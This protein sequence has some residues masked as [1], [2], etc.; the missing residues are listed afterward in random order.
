M[1]RECS[2]RAVDFAMPQVPRSAIEYDRSTSRQTAALVRRSV[3]T[4]SKS[5]TDSVHVPARRSPAD[6]Q[7]RVADGPDDVQRLLVAELPLPAGAGQLA[8]RA[9]IPDVVVAAPARVE[10]R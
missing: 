7:D 9:R 10:R 8:G 1:I 2:A 5:S 3:S 4:T 6:A